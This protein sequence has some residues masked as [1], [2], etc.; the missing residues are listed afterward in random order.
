MKFTAPPNLP[1]V[2]DI[3]PA[4]VPLF[5]PAESTTPTSSICI[6]NLFPVISTNPP[7][8]ALFGR[9]WGKLPTVCPPPLI[10]TPLLRISQVFVVSP[11]SVYVP[12]WSRDFAHVVYDPGTPSP[13]KLPPFTSENVVVALNTDVEAI[14]TSTPSATSIHGPP[15]TKLRLTVEDAVKYLVFSPFTVPLF[16]VELLPNTAL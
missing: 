13:T 11:D 12:G 10:V 1:V 7:D 4:G 3:V 6:N 2:L 5:D 15:V 8:A 14:V 9:A 16:S